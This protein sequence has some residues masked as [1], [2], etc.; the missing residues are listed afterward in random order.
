MEE[1][2]NDRFGLFLAPRPFGGSPFATNLRL[3]RIQRANSA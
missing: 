3:D 1:A 2:L